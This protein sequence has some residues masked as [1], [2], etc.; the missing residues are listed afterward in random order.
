MSLSREEREEFE[1]DTTDLYAND[2]L[3]T[4]AKAHRCFNVGESNYS[5]YKI[6]PWDIWKEYRLD[7]WR[8]DVVK[9]ILRTKEGDDPV[10]DLEKIKHICDELIDLHKEG[11][12][13]E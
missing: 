13:N 8:A 11:Y 12:F 10:K 7:P 6:Q 2:V 9:R 4:F 3:D 5:Q 1:N